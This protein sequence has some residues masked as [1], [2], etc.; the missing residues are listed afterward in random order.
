MRILK[1]FKKFL[2]RYV[3]GTKGV[4]SL[5]LVLIISPLLSVSL[6]LVESARYQSA[7]E[8]MDEVIDAAGFSSLADYDSY[9]DERFGLLALSQESDADSLFNDL[10]S[11]NTASLGSSVTV[12]SSTADGAYALSDTDVLKQQILE[13]SEIMVAVETVYEGLDLDDLIAKLEE[14]LGVDDELKDF[15]SKMSDVAD[16]STTAA[17]VIDFMTDILGEYSD[18]KEALDDYEEAFEEFEE[19][20]DDL[21]EILEDAQEYEEEQE[22][23]DED[24]EDDDDSS[25]SSS[26]SSDNPYTSKIKNA[27]TALSTAASTYQTEASD[28]KEALKDFVDDLTGVVENI[29]SI[30]KKIYSM[31]TA[32]DSTLA[33]QCTTST[34]EWLEKIVEQLSYWV[35]RVVGD[36]YEEDAEEDEDALDEQI[37][38]LKTL[39]STITAQKKKLSSSS[40]YTAESIADALEYDEIYDPISIGAISSQFETETQSSINYMNAL[41]DEDDTSGG[42]DLTD[43]MDLL[44]ELL[45][46][47]VLYDTDLNAIVSTSVLYTGSN[48]DASSSLSVAAFTNIIDACNDFLDGLTSL[49]VIKALKALGEFLVALVEFIGAIVSWIAEFAVNIVTFASQ[50]ASE[51]Y[52]SLLLYGYAAYN[53]PNRTNYSSGKTLAGYSYSKIFKLSGGGSSSASDG[54][55]KSLSDISWTTAGS[56]T[57]FNGAE[58]EYILTGSTSELQNQAAVFFNLYMLRILLDIGFIMS[59][60]YVAAMASAASVASWAVY[61]FEIIAEPLV[62]T[63]VLV[64]G[65][66]EYLWNDVVYLTPAGISILYDD[67]T[68]IVK[69]NGSIPSTLASTI[70]DKIESHF[71]KSSARKKALEADCKLDAGY[72]EHLLLLMMLTVNQ[73]DYMDRLQNIIQMEAKEN[74]DYSFDLSESYTYLYLDVDYTLNAMFNLDALTGSGLF[75]VNSTQYIGY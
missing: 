21:L 27:L 19:K 16:V 63:I 36:S 9:L 29:N 33:E 46:L 73:E 58:L 40:G 12:N 15:M 39:Q 52:N 71:G 67:L 57:M 65:G 54:S 22:A 6:L 3:N 1:R 56:D 49:N 59:D 25:S 14:L 60:T 5:F 23:S 53:L 35:D 38:A 20:Y 13:Y 44:D 50:G 66:S 37:A 28:L 2:N 17:E 8:M 18:Y 42:S 74:Y 32:A 72:T 75:T 62:E 4:I 24:D 61:L 10:L 34:S 48:M 55:L 51:W 47:T 26:S 70:S 7:V 45:G 68:S 43:L 64:N 31:D 30:A 41:A 11:A 69:S